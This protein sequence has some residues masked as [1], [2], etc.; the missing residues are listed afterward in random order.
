MTKM[1]GV[2]GRCAKGKRLI[3]KAPFGH[4]KTRTFAAGSRLD[5]LVAPFVLDRPMSGEAF[6]V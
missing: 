4:W 5:V 1:V 6:L 2:R 3:D